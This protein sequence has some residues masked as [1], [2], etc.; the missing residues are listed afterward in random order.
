MRVVSPFQTLGSLI[1]VNKVY[2]VQ[3]NSHK[4]FKKEMKILPAV[5]I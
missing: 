5:K 1:K 2:V 4:N 3:S